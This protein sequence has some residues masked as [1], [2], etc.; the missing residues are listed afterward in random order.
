MTDLHPLTETLLSH[1]DND[2]LS[3]TTEEFDTLVR[4]ALTPPPVVAGSGVRF[5]DM[6][7]T[8]VNVAGNFMQSGNQMHMAIIGT[9]PILLVQP[10]YDADL[11][12]VTLI[13]TA[14]DLP[15]AGL[16]HVLEALL[17][18]TREIVRIQ[19]QQHE[20]LMDA[21]SSAIDAGN[22]GC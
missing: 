15:P 14:V 11:N 8:L 6:P 5:P 4:E 10:E 3:I 9:E 22:A 19:E 21:R 1:V 20:E 2:G 13:T 17:D 16:V 18:G 7:S 12:E